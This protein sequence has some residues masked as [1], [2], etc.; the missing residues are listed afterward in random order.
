MLVGS[1]A[2]V[3]ALHR[4]LILSDKTFRLVPS[5]AV[6]PRYLYW[7]L[8]SPS[9]RV[10]VRNAISGADGL[11]NNLPL[12]ALRRILIRLP[13]WEEQVE[14][15]AFLDLRCGDLDGLT[16]KVRQAVEL[17]LERRSAVITAAVTGQLNIGKAA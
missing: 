15:A 16:G 9:Y 8:N 4:R 11:A 12:S 3:G 14:I 1:T 2:M 5:P 17:A 10:Q 7:S 6:A 13:S